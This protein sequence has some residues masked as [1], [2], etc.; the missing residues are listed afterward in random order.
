[1]GRQTERATLFSLLIFLLFT[2]HAARAEDAT[3]VQTLSVSVS[4]S[5][6]LFGAQCDLCHE[7][8]RGVSEERCEKCHHA[9]THN[10]A[11]AFAPQCWSCHPEHQKKEQLTHV[12][13]E[14]CTA[15][16]AN[17][18]VK[19]NGATHFAKEVK[20]FVHQHPEFAFTTGEKTKPERIRLDSMGAREADRAKITFPH[21]KHLLK[22]CLKEQEDKPTAPCLKVP[23]DAKEAKQLTCTDCHAPTENGKNLTPITY[24][25]RCQQCHP[26]TFDPQFPDRV[27]PHGSPQLT[28]AFLFLTF[29][30]R[31]NTPPT[32]PPTRSGR[33]TRPVPSVSPLP[34][35]S[36][37]GQRVAAAE[38]YLYD[39]ACDKC[40]TVEK[41]RESFPRVALP[42]ITSAWLPHARFAHKSHRMLE[43][44]ACHPNAAKSNKAT[45]V[46]LPEIQLCRECHRADQENAV[47]KQTTASTACA[48]CHQYHDKKQKNDWDGPFSVQR[49]LTEGA[50]KQARPAG[51]PAKAQP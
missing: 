36:S 4:E 5:H 27:V 33:L 42:A 44:A 51:T 49:V 11:Q 46:L 32:P 23:K 43:C 28:R 48:T 50:P 3:P 13:N 7:A 47:A 10:E 6:T 25:A 39:V 20:D 1:V 18:R 2:A 30:E 45:D 19:N 12:D 15:C 34:T 9:P 24:I 22:P 37:V 31:R 41:S 40:H 38:R 21:D 29:S 16:H 14:Q 26:L 8:L 17:L 35:N